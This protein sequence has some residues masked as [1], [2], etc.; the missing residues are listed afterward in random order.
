VETSTL[1][2]AIYNRTALNSSLT[3]SSLYYSYE[4]CGHLNYFSVDPHEKTLR[5]LPALRVS[6][7][8][9][10]GSGYTVVTK[11]DGSKAGSIVEFMLD[12]FQ[13]YDIEYTIVNVSQAARNFS[14]SSSYTACGYEVALN[15]TDLCIGNFW[16]T[17]SR[18]EF[19]DFSG[20]I[21]V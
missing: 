9:D 8:G 1:S 19:V 11:A 4:T 16:T 2:G 7:P 6:F 10:S 15:G 5:D 17:D 20:A 12:V 3:P 14:P 13:I 21:Y 18:R